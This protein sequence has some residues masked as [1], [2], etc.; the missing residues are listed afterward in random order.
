MKAYYSTSILKMMNLT[1]FENLSILSD[2]QKL[3]LK[4]LSKMHKEVYE[5]LNK[6]QL[7]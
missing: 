4:E 3:S 5:T 2:L 1:I 6:K 7:S